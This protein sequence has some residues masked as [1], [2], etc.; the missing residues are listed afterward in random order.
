MSLSRRRLLAH[1]ALAPLVAGGLAGLSACGENANAGTQ[2][3][4]VIWHGYRG[5][6]KTALEE[7]VALW[8]SRAQPGT[9]RAR[10]VGVPGDAM[11]DKL[12]ASVPR[13]RGPDLFLFGHDRLG[14]WVEAGDTVEPIDFFMDDAT[15]ASYLPGL[16]DAVTY[17]DTLYAL[18]LNYKSIAMFYNRA[19]CPEPPRTTAAL[20]AFARGATDQA[21]GRFGFVYAY[22][23]YFFHGA[24]QNGFG[25]GVFAADGRA[26]L[27][28]E[29][30]RR[31]AELLLKWKDTER[32]LP[33][34]P[35]ASL[36][37]SLF[38][39]GRAAILFN[40][41]WFL[42]EASREIDWGVT[43][44]PAIS[45]AGGAPMRPWVSVE[46]V[47]LAA[48]RPNPEQAWAFAKF[49]TGAEA[50]VIMARGGQQP[51]SRAAHQN[52]ELAA[53]P[54]IQ[55][56][57]AQ[58]EAGVPMPNTSAMT[59]VWSPADKAMKRIVKGEAAPAAALADLQREVTAAMNALE[60]S[61]D[62]E[63]AGR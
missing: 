26:D 60:A 1:A 51:A 23:D 2:D 30:N 5:D 19:L 21:R 59:L 63:G 40:G 35:T 48:G 14:G 41:P 39:G 55:A 9:R 54:V 44:L 27:D 49:L 56:F 47:Y 7:V 4:L 43:V 13:G 33:A 22:D 52:P 17:R 20:E 11:A 61:R 42:G 50:G 6:E 38:N 29:A 28:S 58:V 31:A 24:L 37:S 53:N 57:R 62:R 15:R 8:N 10:A 12:T 46:A 3:D 16:I 18:P 34:D 25:G 45:E 32:V 36:M